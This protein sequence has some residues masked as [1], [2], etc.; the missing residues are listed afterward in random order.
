[1]C[2]YFSYHFAEHSNKIYVTRN[3]YNG[4]DFIKNEWIKK[5][6]KWYYVKEDSSIARNEIFEIHGKKFYFNSDGVLITNKKKYNIG[7]ISYNI[8]KNGEIIATSSNI[9]K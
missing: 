9:R 6:N 1:M 2:N 8:N 3:I 7:G 5:D 4:Q